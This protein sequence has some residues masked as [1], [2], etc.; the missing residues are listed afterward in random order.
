MKRV[1]YQIN[2]QRHFGGGEVYTQFLTRALVELGWQVILFVDPRAGFWRQLDMADARIVPV[3]D[4]AAVDAASAEAGVMIAHAAASGPAWEALAARHRLAC[5]CHMPMQDR[6]VSGFRAARLVLAVSGYVIDTLRAR[7]VANVHPEPM[8]GVAALDRNA[9]R[10]LAAAP[11]RGEL[12]DWDR[13]KFRDRLLAATQP[14]WRRWDQAA[15]GGR[16][17]GISLGIVSRLTPIKQFPALFNI[18]APHLASRDG[19]FLEVFGS[20]GYASVRDLRAALAPLGDRARFWGHQADVRPAYRFVDYV[21]SGLPELEALGLNLIEAQYSGTPVLAVDAPPFTE[22]VK[23]ASSG[24]LYRDPRLDGGADFAALLD[25]ILASPAR[26]NPLDDAAHLERFSF[27]SFRR[28]VARV[29]DG[30]G[31]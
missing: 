27:D 21:L 17:P 26:P 29:L 31:G 1:C 18:I 3:P 23:P 22:T 30:L 19:V 25:R 7:G 24:W 6:D 8:Y 14:V 2:R 28:R 13:R 5:L 12:Y 15:P 16:R 4:L 20:G 9:D 10:R 11:A